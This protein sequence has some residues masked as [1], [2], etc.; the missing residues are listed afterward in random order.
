M[1]SANLFVQ[2]AKLAGVNVRLNKADPNVFYGDRYLSW[3]FAQDFWN[4]RN[5]L[6]QVAASSVK[7]ATYNETHFEDPKFTALIDLAK[8]E[9]DANKRKELLHA[10]QEIEFNTGGFMSGASSASS[11]PTRTSCRVWSR[12]AICRARTSVSSARPSSRP[13]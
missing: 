7:G 4:T 1:E 13:R 3:N 12:T 9:P 10:A 2:Q 8:R 6:P 11:T 5:Y